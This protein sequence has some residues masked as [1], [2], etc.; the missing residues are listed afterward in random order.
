MDGWTIRMIYTVHFSKD[1]S[2]R[3]MF[4]IN[5]KFSGEKIWKAEFLNYISEFK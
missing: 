3:G 5:Y 2:N 1:V 4:K